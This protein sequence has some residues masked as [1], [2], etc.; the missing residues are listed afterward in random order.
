MIGDVI[1]TAESDSSFLTDRSGEARG[2]AD[3]SEAPVTSGRVARLL[4][5][6][7]GWFLTRTPVV[8]ALIARGVPKRTVQAWP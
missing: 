4:R 6:T 8:S 3:S 7:C 1:G 5:Q 2:N